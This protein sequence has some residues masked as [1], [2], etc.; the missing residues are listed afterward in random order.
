MTT[1]DNR[2]RFPEPPTP[3]EGDR[4]FVRCEGGGPSTSR[5]VDYPPPLEITESGGMYVL[6]DDGPHQEWVYVW[7]PAEI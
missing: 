5:L 1:P 7:I 6:N 4:L 2:R 3:R